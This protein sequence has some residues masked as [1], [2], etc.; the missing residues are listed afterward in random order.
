MN[1]CLEMRKAKFWIGICGRRGES[2]LPV[3]R[4]AS[5]S[6][7]FGVL[8]MLLLV[9]DIVPTNLAAQEEDGVD[10]GPSTLNNLASGA[11]TFQM[12]LKP[13]VDLTVH[14]KNIAQKKTQK[15]VLNDGGNPENAAPDSPPVATIIQRDIRPALV[16]VVSQAD[17]NKSVRYYTGGWCA[18][19][20][21]R[22]GL[23]V[24]RVGINGLFF[25]MGLYHF[26]ELLWAEP[27][28]RQP[29]PEVKDGEPKIKLYKEG[30]S[31]LEV[32]AA[33]GLP[34]RYIDGETVW[35]YSYKEDASPIVIPEKL[36]A[37]LL[38]ALSK[39]KS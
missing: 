24:R 12:L 8:I 25:P 13:G 37:A 27:K 35:T 22:K 32:D 6:R 26:P 28:T 3:E 39:Q 14:I 38:R 7:F 29:D 4:V 30:D 1:R 21:A 19:D 23:N 11:Y 15:E 2:L 33:S 36:K 31:T 34:L 20:D 18:F 16:R 17:K 5:G 10:Q 9:L